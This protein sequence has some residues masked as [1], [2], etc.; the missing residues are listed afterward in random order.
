MIRIVLAQLGDDIQLLDDLGSMIRLGDLSLGQEDG[1]VG[2]RN[3][4]LRYGNYR[5]AGGCLMRGPGR[6]C[7]HL[8][9]DGVLRSPLGLAPYRGQVLQLLILHSYCLSQGVGAARMQL[10]FLVELLG[11]H[12]LLVELGGRS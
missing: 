8:G 7:C 4:G 2:R 1:G 11:T 5:L 3:R 9:R 10:L 6:W 12:L